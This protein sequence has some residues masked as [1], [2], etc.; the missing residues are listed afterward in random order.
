MKIPD[1]GHVELGTV[2][3]LVYTQERKSLPFLL[4]SLKHTESR[5]L[6]MKNEFS[7][8]SLVTMALFAALLC[9]SAYISIPL[10][11]G[12]HLTLLNFVVLL[13]AFLFPVGQSAL[14]ISVWLLLG[15]IGI[16]VFISGAS[17]VG[18]LFGGWGGYNLAF[19][20]VA[21]LVPLMR[22]REYRRIS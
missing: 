5:Y 17:G 14:I 1:N 2:Q 18:Y 4:L 16:P 9:V 12:S 19:L 11:N 15:A 22:G 3:K 7:T 13:I 10:P 6:I 20:V 8:K 21:I